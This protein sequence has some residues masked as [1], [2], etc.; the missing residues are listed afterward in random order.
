MLKSIADEAAVAINNARLLAKQRATIL[1][2][3][4]LDQAKSRFLGLVSH[5]LRTP[6]KLGP[7]PY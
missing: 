6:M 7:W 4:E 1:K 5:E 2:L 3:Q